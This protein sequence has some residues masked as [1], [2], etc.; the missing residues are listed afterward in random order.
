MS[1]KSCRT[2]QQDQQNRCSRV[3][4]INFFTFASFLLSPELRQ[5][6]PLAWR[7]LTF[8]FCSQREPQ[9]G[10]SKR[11]LPNGNPETGTSKREFP[12]GDFQTRTPKREFPNDNTQTGIPKSEPPNGNFQTGINLCGATEPAHGRCHDELTFTRSLRGFATG[13]N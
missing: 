6:N 5:I 13:A 9:M 11:E 10:A 7:T 12:N 3:H 8:S 4:N 2:Y 1:W